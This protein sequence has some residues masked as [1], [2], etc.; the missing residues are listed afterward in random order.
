VLDAL[1]TT[2]Y[3]ALPTLNID[4]DGTR[5]QLL[6]Y[7]L[8]GFGVI[9]GLA[10]WGWMARRRRQRAIPATAPMPADIG[11]MRAEFDGFYVSTTLDG[12][13]LNRVAVRGLGFRARATFAVTDAGVI[14]ALPGNTVFIPRDTIREV[15]TANYTI[16]RVV[17]PGGLVLVAWT[18]GAGTPSETRLDSYLRVAETAELVSAIAS[19]LPAPSGSAAR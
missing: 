10:I 4:D 5:T 7:V 19:L 8:I 9:I 2:V 14:L 12:Q 18:L 15:T 6:I 17:E 16:D 3:S 13:P 11:A 1:G